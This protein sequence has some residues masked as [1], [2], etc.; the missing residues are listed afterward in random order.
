MDKVYDSLTFQQKTLID[1]FNGLEAVVLS[2]DFNFWKIQ[3]QDLC[4]S[5]AVIVSILS[6]ETRCS[7]SVPS[8][9]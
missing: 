6:F 9:V 2:L 5:Y 3:D 7:I 1:G 4:W 8:P